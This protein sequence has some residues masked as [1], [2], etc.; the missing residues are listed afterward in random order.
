MPY[1]INFRSKLHGVEV[2]DFTYGNFAT[3]LDAAKEI[4]EEVMR[5]DD[6]DGDYFS[7][8]TDNINDEGEYYDRFSWLH[9]VD[10]VKR[11]AETAVMWVCE[12]GYNN[13]NYMEW[14]I[15]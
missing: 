11:I 3:K 2:V 10:D 12:N 8:F 4:S 1:Q 7:H 6:S 14:F 13:E 5:I 15:I 9:N